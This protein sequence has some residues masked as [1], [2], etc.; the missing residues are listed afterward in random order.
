M[1]DHALASSDVVLCL[2]YPIDAAASADS[3]SEGLCE[4]RLAIAI[5]LSVAYVDMSHQG[6]YPLTA[7][8]VGSSF[9]RTVE[10]ALPWLKERALDFSGGHA[11]ESP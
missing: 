11:T 9:F 8:R 2:G 5:G 6:V 4:L 10:D 3:F 1:G 7:F